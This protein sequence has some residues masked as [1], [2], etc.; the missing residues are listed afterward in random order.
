MLVCLW[1]DAAEFAASAGLCWL[2]FLFLAADL[3]S[4]AGPLSG[5]RRA[6]ALACA[7]LAVS[8]CVVA[9]VHGRMPAEALPGADAEVSRD[10][11]R[12]PLRFLPLSLGAAWFLV[13]AAPGA[14]PWLLLALSCPLFTPVPDF[15][16][17][18]LD[19]SPCSAWGAQ[20]LLAALGGQVSRSGAVLSQAGTR[21][22][23]A[24]SCS[25]LGA[26]A[27]M[28]ALVLLLGLATESRPAR[29][30]ALAPLAVAIGLLVNFARLALLFRLLAID[31]ARFDFWHAQSGSLFYHAVAVA[32]FL[33]VAL[34]WLGL[35]GPAR[36][37]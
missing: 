22:F 16:R 17:G 37:R 6:A 15:L 4:R 10:A 28:L 3:P 26:I 19:L 20:Q 21:M 11:L 34:P 14:R 12:A 2:V 33:L 31:R 25:G 9:W 32:L 18:P 29:M 5:R 27:Q 36:R 23:V 24:T 35:V 7:L 30:L 1:I 13:G 8:L